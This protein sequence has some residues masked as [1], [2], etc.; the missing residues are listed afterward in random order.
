[1][2]DKEILLEAI[3]IISEFKETVGDDN[4]MGYKFIRTYQ[5]LIDDIIIFMEEVG[6]LE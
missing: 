5:N 3:D 6:F 2:T 1:M 4:P